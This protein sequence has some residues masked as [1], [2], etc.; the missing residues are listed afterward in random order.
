LPNALPNPVRDPSAGIVLSTGH[1]ACVRKVGSH[2]QQRRFTLHRFTFWESVAAFLTHANALQNHDFITGW[3]GPHP[4]PGSR[5][6]RILEHHAAI[7]D[8]HQ[9]KPHGSLRDQEWSAD[10]DT[11]GNLAHPSMARFQMVE[12]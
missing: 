1:F 5:L 4:D 11:H 2:A 10:P 12:L 6:K 9:W 7:A 3:N 8:R